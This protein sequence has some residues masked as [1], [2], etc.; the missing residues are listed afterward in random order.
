MLQ[1][2]FH[3]LF[4]WSPINTGWHLHWIWN[5]HFSILQNLPSNDIFLFPS[6]H[7]RKKFAKSFLTFVTCMN[8]SADSATQFHSFILLYSPHDFY[9]PYYFQHLP[10][11]LFFQHSCQPLRNSVHTPTQW[12]QYC[13]CGDNMERYHHHSDL[14]SNE[15][16]AL[17]H[18]VSLN[19]AHLPPLFSNSVHCC[20]LELLII[21]VRFNDVPIHGINIVYILLKN[22]FDGNP[23]TT[24]DP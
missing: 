5:D 14:N 7:T 4:L 9:C 23:S 12:P 22:L 17:Q 24:L 1:Q 19:K 18:I 16:K 8:A 11:H 6:I 20:T 3:S 10:P 2:V 21:R 13:S 15:Y